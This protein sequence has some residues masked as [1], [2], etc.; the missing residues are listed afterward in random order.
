MIKIIFWGIIFLKEF[1]AVLVKTAIKASLGALLSLA[2]V[3]M[4]YAYS[5][6][7]HIKYRNYK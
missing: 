6:Y 3:P 5:V 2:V 7:T 1:L 4:I